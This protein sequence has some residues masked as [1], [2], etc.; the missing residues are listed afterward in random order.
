MRPLNLLFIQSPRNNLYMLYYII[1]LLSFQPNRYI[2]IL[3][4]SDF[5]PKKKR[6]RKIRRRF[7]SLYKLHIKRWNLRMIRTKSVLVILNDF[8]LVINIHTC[9]GRNKFT[10]NNIFLKAKEIVTVA[11]DS[12]IS[13]CLCCFLEGSC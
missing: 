4:N 8:N 3:Y 9:T 2:F 7:M 5:Y 11:S 1:F 13:K 12:C 10:N 6:P